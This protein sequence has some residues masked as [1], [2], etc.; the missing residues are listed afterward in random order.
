MSSPSN[1]RF[2]TLGIMIAIILGAFIGWALPGFAPYVSWLGQIF[3]LSLAMIVMPLV[4]TSIM[5]GMNSVGDVRRLGRIGG[6][7]LV[8]YFSTTIIAVV[9]GLTLVSQ[10][11]PGVR[12][13]KAAHEYA[14]I[15]LSPASSQMAPAAIAAIFRTL[16]PAIRPNFRRFWKKW[17]NRAWMSTLKKRRHCD[18]SAPLKC[19]LVLRIKGARNPWTHPAP[20]HSCVSSSIKHW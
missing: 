1:T 12:A 19:A 4:L 5:D 10:I 8:Y 17:R 6:K 20:V 18:G 11:Q 3:K 16:K 13:P 15:E 2:L 7:T 14:L 9:I